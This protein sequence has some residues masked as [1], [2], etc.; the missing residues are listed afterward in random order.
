MVAMV[1]HCA[2]QTVQLRETLVISLLLLSPSLSLSF[3]PCV[4]KRATTPIVGQNCH[5]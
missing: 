5:Y 1:A 3:S 4:Y 2:L